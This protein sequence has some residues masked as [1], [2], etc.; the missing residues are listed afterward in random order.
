MPIDH[1]AVGDRIDVQPPSA[2]GLEGSAA[3]QIEEKR[4]FRF[5][6]TSLGL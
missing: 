3:G 1:V 6:I 4:A 2:I 5:D